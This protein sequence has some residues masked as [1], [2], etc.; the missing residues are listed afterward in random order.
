MGSWHSF[1]LFLKSTKKANILP[2]E[3]RIAETE[4]QYKGST[5]TEF[6]LWPW[7]PL[8]PVA[9]LSCALHPAL[10]GVLEGKVSQP[11]PWG[12][13]PPLSTHSTHPHRKG[14]V[15]KKYSFMGHST[16]P[17]ISSLFMGPRNIS[18]EEKQR[19]RAFHQCKPPKQLGPW[20]GMS[21][22]ALS[23]RTS[24]WTGSLQAAF[25]EVPLHLCLWLR[26]HKLTLK[27]S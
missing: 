13:P 21:A 23:D 17:I 20:K 24:A 5:W 9:N 6:S 1:G 19:C 27:V 8:C 12:F 11:L 22:P 2:A 10:P 4:E 26:A 25:Q 18:T 3:P 16:S 15:S 7:P 14:E